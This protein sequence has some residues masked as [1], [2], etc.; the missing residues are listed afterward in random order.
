MRRKTP[1]RNHRDVEMNYHREERDKQK[2]LAS[3]NDLKK[4]LILFSIH[5]DSL[6]C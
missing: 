2:S 4:A 6:R 5:P 3:K 1:L